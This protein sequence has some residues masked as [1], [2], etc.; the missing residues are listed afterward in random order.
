MEFTCLH[1]RGNSLLNCQLSEFSMVISSGGIRQEIPYATIYKISVHKAGRHFYATIWA[2]GFKPV[3]VSNK[4]LEGQRVIEQSPAYA[5]FLRVL[6]F[7]LKKKGNKPVIRIGKSYTKIWFTIFL[8]VS[9]LLFALYFFGGLLDVA[10]LNKIF[11]IL[12]ICLGLFASLSFFSFLRK[13]KPAEELPA[14]Y[15]PV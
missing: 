11:T 10:Y 12:L 7:H 14:E 3:F 15:L 6:H 2:E 1:N 9:V 5:T 13:S 8:L 4:R